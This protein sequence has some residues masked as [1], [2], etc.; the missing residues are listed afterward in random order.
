MLSLTECVDLSG[1]SRDEA[2]LIAEHE[3]I[4][5]I[6]AA[7]LGFTLLATPKGIYRLHCIFLDALEQA[8]LAGNARHARHIDRVYTRFRS[9]YPL[10]RVV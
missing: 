7:E 2:E 9:A 4:S 6:V 1:L 3:H 5:V 8:K 10:P